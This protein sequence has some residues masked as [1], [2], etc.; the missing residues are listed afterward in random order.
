LEFENSTK[1]FTATIDHSSGINFSLLQI[2]TDYDDINEKI[3]T[4]VAENDI[5]IEKVIETLQTEL[6]TKIQAE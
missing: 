5:K 2:S 6:Q 4:L 1:N 3:N